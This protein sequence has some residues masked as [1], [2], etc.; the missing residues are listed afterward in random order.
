MRDS[1][2]FYRSFWE[3]VKDLPAEQFKPAVSA[4]IEYGL[5]EQAPSTSGIEKTI[6]T[7]TKPLIDANNRKYQ[8]GTKGGRPKTKPEPNNNL[9]I[10]KAE[11]SRNQTISK[12]EPNVYVNDNVNVKDDDNIKTFKPPSAVE[13]TAYCTEKGY[14][15]DADAFIDFYDSKGWMVGKNKMKD[16]KASVRNWNRNQQSQRQGLT[17]KG[18]KPNRFINFH[19][20]E[21]DGTELEAQILKKRMGKNE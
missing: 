11:P 2:L 9:D 20:R 5:D 3:A 18:S 13:V 7:L 1:V 17:T 8:N 15:V 14:K 6:Y 10:T 4:I 16:W 12:A 21:N 19:Q